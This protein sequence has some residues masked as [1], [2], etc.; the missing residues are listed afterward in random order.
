MADIRYSTWRIA[1]DTETPGRLRLFTAGRGMQGQGFQQMTVT[2]TNEAA[3]PG[4]VDRPWHVHRMDWTVFWEHAP[5]HADTLTLGAR[6]AGL[7]VYGKLRLL[8]NGEEVNSWIPMTSG[9]PYGPMP[10]KLPLRGGIETDISLG[11]AYRFAAD[12]AI[13]TGWRPAAPICVQVA[14]YGVHLDSPRLLYSPYP[15]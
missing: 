4:A 10:D 6:P 5:D 9:L 15:S 14:L 12:L 13:G 3:F 11:A 7:L 2:E 8:V 1:T